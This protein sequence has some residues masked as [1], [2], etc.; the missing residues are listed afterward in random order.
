MSLGRTIISAIAATMLVWTGGLSAAVYKSVDAE[1]N[2]VYTDEPG[3]DA[4]P[5]DLPPLSTV[6]A[7]KYDPDLLKSITS[8]D[9]AEA[10]KSITIVSPIADE[11]LRDNTGAVS[12]SVSSEP[13]LNKAAGH[14]F[15]YYLDGKA[16]D[17]PTASDRTSFINV[18]RGAHDVAVAVVD[19]SGKEL[20]KSNS[21]RF[22]LHRQSVNFPAGPGKP[23]P[24]KSQGK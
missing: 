23:T 3:A 21:V 22:Y 9:K 1:G 20:I 7:P 19:V 5:V 6:P 17:E 13:V 8:D 14:R 12:V 15:K 16:P 4:K 2:V 24:F 18:D 11:T 10:Y